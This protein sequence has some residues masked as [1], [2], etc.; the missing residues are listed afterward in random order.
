MNEKQL[1]GLGKVISL[2]LR[3]KPEVIGITLDKNG[4]TRVESLL[5]KMNSAGFPITREQLHLVVET[6]NKK[7][8]LLSEDGILIRASQGHS[9]N[10]DLELAPAI[11]PPVLFHGTAIKNLMSIR[12]QGLISGT[13]LHVHLSDNENTAREVGSRHG[14]PVVLQVNA[15]KMHEAGHPFF[16][17]DN[18]VW[19][20]G[21][22]DPAFLV[23]P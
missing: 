15:R 2:V 9:V 11:P 21:S 18:K 7:R 5:E 23:F 20:T 3:H 17:S 10:I 19:L 8:F 6:N 4:W 1:K 14:S 13:R 22:V 12:Q 16:L